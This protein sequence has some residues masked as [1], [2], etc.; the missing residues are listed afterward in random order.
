MK[1]LFMVC[2]LVIAVIGVMAIGVMASKA[3]ADPI[4][5]DI[6]FSGI[7]KQNEPSLKKA[8]QFNKF[9][10]VLVSE[11]GEIG[12]D[13]WANSG[14][15][16]TFNPFEFRSSFEPNPLAPLLTFDVNGETGKFYLTD[17]T[18]S[19][20]KFKTISMYGNGI[21][22]VTGF[23]DA[24]G[25]WH[26]TADRAGRKK[27]KFFAW[28]E[29]EPVPELATLFESL[30]VPPVPEQD[31]PFEASDVVPVPESATMLLLGFGLIGIAGLGRKRLRR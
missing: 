17:L 26:F 21:A 12:D 3:V 27:S 20:R 1:K 23:D 18:I 10:E 25:V 11:T 16:F 4:Y 28:F 7:T 24:F 9:R 14:Q 31:T 15:S 5:G 13:A 8:T 29:V 2:S 22:S 30:E 6:S 19:N